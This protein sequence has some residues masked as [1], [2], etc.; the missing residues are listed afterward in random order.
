MKK[1]LWAIIRRY[2]TRYGYSLERTKI[3]GAEP[4]KLWLSDIPFLE[5]WRKISSNTMIDVTRAYMLYQFLLN[6]RE[7]SG[8]AAEIGVWRGGT[9]Q[10]IT[11]ILSDKPIFLFDTFE[12]LPEVAPKHD[13]NYHVKGEFGNTSYEQVNHLFSE[14]NNVT[15]VKGVFPKSINDNISRIN[16]FCF[17]HVDVDLYQSAIDCC[18]YF[19]PRLSKGGIIIFDDYGFGTCPGVRHAVDEYFRDKK[20]HFYLTTGQYI[21]FNIQH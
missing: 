7:I 17:V 13:K 6:A 1:I 8:A 9:G 19:Y 14:N 3:S 15:I 16:N 5:L 18:E 2:L 20:G 10:L 11:T 21:A 4:M 12:G